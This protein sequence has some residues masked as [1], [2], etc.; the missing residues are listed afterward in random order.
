ME[1]G[2]EDAHFIA[3]DTRSAV[4]GGGSR[5]TGDDG[6]QAKSDGDAGIHLT[7]HKIS[8]REPGKVCYAAKEWMANTPNVSRS[9]A[10]GSLHRL[11]RCWVACQ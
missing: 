4:I 7:R 9:L 6:S 5:N 1:I 3:I 11:V 8:A 10:R 2:H